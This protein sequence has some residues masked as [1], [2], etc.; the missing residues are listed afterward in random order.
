METDLYHLLNL[1]QAA[2]DLIVLYEKRKKKEG[3]KKGIL[4]KV[5]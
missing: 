3:K 4:Q 5:K 1:F 2:N